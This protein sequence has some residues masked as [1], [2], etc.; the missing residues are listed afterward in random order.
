MLS[1]LGPL[2]SDGGNVALTV[3]PLDVVRA[4]LTDQVG[5][6]SWI[7]ELSEAL[8]QR[9]FKK[10]TLQRQLRERRDILAAIESFLLAH[11]QE[12]GAEQGF[13]SGP[14]AEL[15]KRT[16]AYHLASTEQ[17]VQL[18]DLFD[19]L[20]ANIAT[21]V[22]EPEKRRVFGRTLFGVGDAIGLERW[23]AENAQR[24]ASCED[25]DALFS[26][27]WPC[28]A[29]R[30]ENDTFKKWR[31]TQ[32]TD[33]FARGWI[34]GDSFAALHSRM[35]AGGARIGLGKYPRKPKVEHVVEMGENALGFD[36]AHV[37]G[38]I[39]ELYEL[40]SPDDAATLL[41]FLQMLQKQL[42]YG[43]PFGPSILLYE[44]GFSDRPLALDLAQ[45]VS[46]VSSR[47]EVRISM[48][49]KRKQV[50]AVLTQYPQY[51][52]RIFERLMG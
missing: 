30:I 28:I 15:A 33:A 4:Y 46:E 16:L 5:S 34:A 6:G 45:I 50:E 22:A 18:I 23:V 49:R 20:A 41:P 36:G 14:V 42:K 39:T 48:R 52:W 19:L 10:E 40:L 51:F 27:V 7:D 2:K 12:D 21:R 24:I 26:V 37:L 29:A 13:G 1:A 44:A 43:L 3:D 47:T 8:T 35:L 11:W 25:G 17:R 38:A 31:P 9:W 32:M